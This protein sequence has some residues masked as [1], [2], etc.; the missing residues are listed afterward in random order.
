MYKISDCTHLKS[1]EKQL[2]YMTSK[3]AVFGHTLLT[4][5]AARKKATKVDWRQ[6]HRN[7]Q[8]VNNKT[9]DMAMNS[10]DTESSSSNI[11]LLSGWS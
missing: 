4:E 7:S 2:E 9:A 8:Q 5:E 6:G 11:P 3:Y 1:Q 10:R